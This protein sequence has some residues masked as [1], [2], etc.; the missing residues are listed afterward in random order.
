[1]STPAMALVVSV[2]STDDDPRS[3]CRRLASMANQGPMHLAQALATATQVYPTRDDSLR[4]TATVLRCEFRM[5]NTGAA[6]ND[7]AAR[8]LL[9]R[10]AGVQLLDAHYV[11][12]RGVALGPVDELRAAS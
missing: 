10:L 12:A 2:L 7:E 6:V 4:G 11:D 1:M 3:F 9:G 5:R 8:S